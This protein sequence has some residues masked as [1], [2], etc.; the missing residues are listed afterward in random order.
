MGSDDIEMNDAL[1]DVC[2]IFIIVVASVELLLLQAGYMR[3]VVKWEHLWVIAV[4]LFS[5][6]S[7]FVQPDA[8]FVT[9][10]LEDGSSVAWLRYA[11]PWG[12]NP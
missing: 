2:K 12:S 9:F 11:V 8:K 3:G 10:H 1:G 4:E 6:V 7:S 5:Y